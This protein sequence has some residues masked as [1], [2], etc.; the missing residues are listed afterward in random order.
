MAL[1]N[2]V[3]VCTC[4]V[5]FIE[6]FTSHF[7]ATPIFIAFSSILVL[8]FP[9]RLVPLDPIFYTFNWNRATLLA[10]FAYSVISILYEKNPVKFPA[11]EEEEDKEAVTEV[12]KESKWCP[13]YIPLFVSSVQLLILAKNY[14]LVLHLAQFDWP[15][16][17]DVSVTLHSP[18]SFGN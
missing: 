10:I 17:I 1:T 5:A 15:P 4:L 16:P 11:E 9:H 13:L 2:Q 7:L 8:L 6:L 14:Y 12:A 3:T 18:V